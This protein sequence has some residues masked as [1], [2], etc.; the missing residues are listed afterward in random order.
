MTDLILK[1]K[2]E[3]EVAMSKE[4]GINGV[5]TGFTD[6]DRVTSGWQRSDMIVIAASPG[7]GKTA[8][9]I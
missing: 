6:L 2:D 7:M 8:F 3:I 1:A 9:V 5:A 4:D